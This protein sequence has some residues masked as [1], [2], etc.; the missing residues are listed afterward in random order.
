M[1]LSSI[2]PSRNRKRI[3]ATNEQLLD[4]KTSL[5]LQLPEILDVI[6][7]F[8]SQY[9]LNNTIRYVCKQ[10]LAI[11]RSYIRIHGLWRDRTISDYSHDCLFAH[12]NQVTDL[13][14][15]NEQ[16]GGF[17][18]DAAQKWNTLLE[19]IDALKDTN[20][21][22]I[23]KIIFSNA[24]NFMQG[25]MYP[26]LSRIESLTD[27][28]IHRVL[29][30]SVHLGLIIDSCPNL[31]R[32]SI[33]HENASRSVR[34][35]DTMI[36]RGPVPNFRSKVGSLILKRGQIEQAIMESILSRCPELLV[37]KMIE[38]VQ[39][40]SEA[41][42]INRVEFFTKIAESCPK[43]KHFH[44][45]I[46]EQSMSVVDAQTLSGMF[47]NISVLDFLGHN[48]QHRNKSFHPRR[49]LDLNT[50]SVLDRDIKDCTF[51]FVFAPVFDSSFT[52]TITSLEII[53]A[54]D[55]ME[56]SYISRALH[57]FLCSASSLLHLLAPA[58]PYFAEYL[59]L[60][61]PIFADEFYYPRSCGPT[62][63]VS[64]ADFLKRE[65]WACHQ[66][67]TLQIKFV[68]RDMEDYADEENAR[69]MFGYISKVCPN[70]RELAIDR[71]ELK[72][73]LES[74]F[75]FLSRLQHL[76]RLTILTWTKTKLEKKDLEWMARNPVGVDKTQDAAN[77][78]WDDE[79]KECRKQ[80]AR[81]I[82]DE[83][84][85]PM[86]EYLGLKLLLLRKGKVKDLETYLP[87]M[88]AEVRPD[89]EF[90][91]N[92]CEWSEY[93]ENRY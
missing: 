87:A 88:I 31:L 77:I 56:C 42:S 29:F 5:V 39:V 73:N 66:L 28:Q 34:I 67:R 68:S 45:S 65:V 57:K 9:T 20:Q 35:L 71:K 22:R 76:Q 47:S 93:Y 82:H 90:S 85:W 61:G 11:A 16:T 37:L 58:V 6:F 60:H 12:F 25:T 43:M 4:T 41:E 21:L 81:D 83:R 7:S 48:E 32:I 36:P 54:G 44:F 1:I 23:T 2:F 69:I 27:I 3:Y 14:I 30:H 62:R 86:M 8:L 24:A 63:H 92:S 15:V 75:C 91:C 19:K 17:L 55:R 79:L 46:Q 52:N 59:D 64:K 18:D 33:G 70:L 53:R 84:C 51:S 80:L 26:M 10:W 74:G 38:I 50:I 78:N 13:R 40:G 49:Q 89:I 72:L